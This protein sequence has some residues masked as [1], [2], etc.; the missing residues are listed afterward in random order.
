MSIRAGSSGLLN[1][2][3]VPS[4]IHLVA[5]LKKL[6]SHSFL[7]LV[8]DYLLIF[9]GKVDQHYSPCRP[10]VSTLFTLLPSRS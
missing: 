2:V 5:G 1:K 8:R 10:C 3:L 9:A 6:R 4:N 7:W